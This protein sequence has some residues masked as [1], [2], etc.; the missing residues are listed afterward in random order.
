MV[1]VPVFSRYNR[2]IEKTAIYYADFY[3][4]QCQITRMSIPFKNIKVQTDDK[5]N[6]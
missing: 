5:K 1:I 3:D 2:I 4:F 6:R